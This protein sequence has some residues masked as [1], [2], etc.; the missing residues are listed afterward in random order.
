MES[1][2]ESLGV[3]LKRFLKKSLIVIVLGA[4]L[5]GVGYYFYRT[6][7]ISEGTRS[8]ILYKISKKGSIFKTYEG[9]IQL[10][11]ST[12]VSKASTW[13]FSVKDEATYITLQ[14]LEGS[15]VRLYYNQMVHAFPWQGETDYIVYKAEEL[16]E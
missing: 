13:D 8:G 2:S 11:G 15:N 3:K 16:T 12:I 7:T 5:F 14:K 6:Y 1:N 9:Q 10:A 4:I